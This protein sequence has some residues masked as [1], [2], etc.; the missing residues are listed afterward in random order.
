MNAQDFYEGFRE[1][2][3]YLGAGF[4]CKDQVDVWIEN[5]KFC[6][7]RNGVDIRLPIPPEQPENQ[8]L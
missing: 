4:H 8:K 3:D 1:S 6:M 5:G 2:L 7:T